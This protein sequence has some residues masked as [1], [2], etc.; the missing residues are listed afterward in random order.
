MRRERAIVG[1]V[2]SASVVLL[3]RLAAAQSLW[4]DPAHKFAWCENAGFL[5][6]ADAGAPSAPLGARFYPRSASNYQGFFKG[7]VWGEN[8][9]WIN[10]GNGPADGVGPYINTT[11]ANFGI[12]VD[13]T[14]KLTGYA[15][16]ENAGW[17]NFDTALTGNPARI[18]WTAGVGM[19]GARLRGYVWSENFGWVNLDHATVYVGLAAGCP[20]D[21]N[22]DGFVDDSD[23][24]IFLAAYNI[25]DCSDPA[26]AFGC[27]A[28]LNGDGLVEDADFVQFLKGYNELICP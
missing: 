16:G 7:F 3:S 9:G 13:G 6:W 23:F 28:D 19:P 10:L 15:W 8:I 17:F 4:T 2:G 21:L 1:L 12:N 26:A 18:D 20:A 14:G 25:L 5:N 22:R 11:G 27:P 24:V